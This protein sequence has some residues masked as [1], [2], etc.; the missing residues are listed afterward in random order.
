MA[1]PKRNGRPSEYNPA[2]GQALA[3]DWATG[4][5]TRELAEKHGISQQTFYNWQANHVD[6][7]ERLARARVLKAEHHAEQAGT[8]L[9]DT[10]P[11]VLD[12]KIDPRRTAQLVKLAIKESDRQ[13]WLAGAMDSRYS[14]RPDL[15]AVA[16]AVATV[17][18]SGL[19]GPAASLPVPSPTPRLEDGKGSD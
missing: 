10:R 14:N 9:T 7:V 4:M 5:G 1:E 13:V 8:V 17:L 18:F 11:D 2:R 15:A 12:E 3:E 6:L 16:T 19:A